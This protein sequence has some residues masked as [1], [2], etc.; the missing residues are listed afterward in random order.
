M[1]PKEHKLIKIEAPH[2]DEIL[3]LAI[4][5]ILDRK[6]QNSMMLKLKFTWNLAIL[7]VTNSGLE[8][9]IFYPKEKLGILDLRSI[10]Y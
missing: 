6:T 3:G 10:G 4:V 8:T 2:V 1:K 9:V 5:K 7:D